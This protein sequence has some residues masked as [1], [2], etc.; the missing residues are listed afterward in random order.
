MA[1]KYAKTVSYAVMAVSAVTLVSVLGWG[2]LTGRLSGGAAGAAAGRV[3]TAAPGAAELAEAGELEGGVLVRERDG[4]A[5]GV[6]HPLSGERLGTIELEHPVAAMQPTP[7]GVSVFLGSGGGPAQ[8]EVFSTIE[9]HREAVVPLERELARAAGAREPEHLLFSENGDTLFVTWADSAVVSVY[10]HVMR[11][12]E[13]QAEFEIPASFGP[14]YRNRRAT[15]LYRR[16]PDGLAVVFARNGER[17][18]TVAVEAELWRFNPSYT[19]LWG[20]DGTGGVWLVE[21]R[22]MAPRRI[23]A[24]AVAALAPVLP[25]ETGTALL[26]SAGGDEVLAFEARSGRPLGSIELPAPAAHLAESGA[27]SVWAVGEDG[28]V[29]VIDPIARQVLDR[30]QLDGGAPAA[31]V[32]SIVQREGSFACF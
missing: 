29:T 24:P 30:L 16:T 20:V 23:D 11:E 13:L 1:G 22:S 32:S 5:I 18:D 26:L 21:E 7:G 28:G 3:G 9:Y 15:R 19:H 27:G 25:S 12:L 17:I 31:V 14:L 10:S 4:R 6:F 2:I 8:L